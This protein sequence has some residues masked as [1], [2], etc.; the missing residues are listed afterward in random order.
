MY[1][2]IRLFSHFTQ[3]LYTLGTYTNA[4]TAYVPRRKA[5]MSTIFNLVFTHA[6][7]VSVGASAICFQR[8]KYGSRLFSTWTSNCYHF[9]MPLPA[10]SE[11]MWTQPQPPTFLL[12]VLLD[13]K[14]LF[15]GLKWAVLEKDYHHTENTGFI[16][17]YS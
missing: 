12:Q 13:I 15:S 2:F 11:L 9:K 1:L 5:M 17:M 6:C 14:C 8:C 16:S 7:P 3:L 10:N 4:A